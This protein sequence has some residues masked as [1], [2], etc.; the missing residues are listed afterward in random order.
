MRKPRK[1]LSDEL[2]GA[3][4]EGGLSQGAICRATEIDPGLMSRFMNERSMLSLRAADKVA[5][6]L[7][8]RITKPKKT[9]KRGKR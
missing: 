6:L 5:Q 4:R 9:K 8:L 1:K 2:R 3:I 7:G